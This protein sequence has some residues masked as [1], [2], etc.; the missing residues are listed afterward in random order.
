[1]RRLK[2]NI[3]IIFVVMGMILLTS[4][5]KEKDVTNVENNEENLQ[6]QKEFVDVTGVTTLSSNNTW[7]YTKDMLDCELYEWSEDVVLPIPNLECSTGM[8][9]I[10]GEFF[11]LGV[12]YEEWQEYVGLLIEKYDAYVRYDSLVSENDACFV[13]LLDMENNLM[14]NVVWEKDLPYYNLNNTVEAWVYVGSREKYTSLT[15]EEVLNKSL[16]KLG[17]SDEKGFKV[18]NISSKGNISDGFDVYYLATSQ[19]YRELGEENPYMYLCVVKDDEIVFLEPEAI[20]VGDDSSIEFLRVGDSWKMYLV[21]TTYLCGD[22]HHR[23]EMYDLSD[24]C[25]VQESKETV[26]NIEELKDISN[27]VLK[28]NGEEIDI[29]KL[30]YNRSE[31]LNVKEPYSTWL[32]GSKVAIIDDEGI[33]KVEAEIETE[34]VED[35]VETE[36]DYVETEK[37]NS[38]ISYRFEGDTLYVSGRGY[39]DEEDKSIWEENIHDIEK[40]VIEEGVTVIGYSAFREMPYLEE[41]IISGSVK[42]IENEAFV[43]CYKLNNVQINEGVEVIE[44]QAFCYCDLMNINIPKS[45]KEL[46]NKAFAYSVNL[47]NY[48]IPKDI[49]LGDDVFYRT[50]MMDDMVAEN[51]L[52]IVEG[53]LYDGKLAE[54][55]VVIPD[56][57]TKIAPSAFYNNEKMTS[58]EIPESVVSIGDSAFASCKK[59]RSV[60]CKAVIEE[61]GMSIFSNCS[62]LESVELIEGIK[63]ISFG[64]FSGCTSLK[65]ID[66]PKSVEDI[67]SQAFDSCS[68]LES[69]DISGVVSLGYDVFSQCG[70]LKS[71]K[72]SKKL[73]TVGNMLFSGC[74]SFET[75]YGEKGSYAEE[76]ARDLDYEFIIE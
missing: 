57:V 12:D 37:E 34:T 22:S 49:E 43:C 64:M 68:K 55:N 70:E 23:M 35:Y 18:I 1:M 19:E 76:L 46:G 48:K 32:L 58:V 45:V 75:I 56:T 38:N 42:V 36:K 16:N 51:G 44:S 31:N 28:K 33:K 7:K 8:K 69:I 14:A 17:I 47:D 39:V 53:I 21:T 61:I 15:N 73:I 54:G 66:I 26:Y 67:H 59:L 9:Y 40:I 2:R 41:V 5:G 63:L 62:L 74:Y 11:A 6:E 4:C 52:A 71:V 50:K 10:D 30:D 60:K 27:I 65:N 3:G 20:G 25:F 24:G 72:T 29:Y 13:Q